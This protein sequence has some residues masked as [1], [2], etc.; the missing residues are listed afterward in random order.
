MN[1]DPAPFEARKRPRGDT[2]QC[3]ESK[4]VRNQDARDMQMTSGCS[5]P[6]MKMLRTELW[7][8]SQLRKSCF[9]CESIL[10]ASCPSPKVLANSPQPHC[11]ARLHQR[12]QRMGTFMV[13]VSPLPCP[14]IIRM[15]ACNNGPNGTKLRIGHG[16]HAGHTRRAQL[17]HRSSK[18][19]QQTSRCSHANFECLMD[20]AQL[21][22]P[23]P[24]LQSPELGSVAQQ[25][26][27]LPG[28]LQ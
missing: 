21:P 5:Q 25:L 6:D 2:L 28:A 13:C 10:P 27:R 22:I 9:D 16:G 4:P 18:P 12:Q 14:T 1:A 7:P 15:Q 26:L 23:H 11:P 3:Q 24:W 8:E 20:S 17:V 19:A